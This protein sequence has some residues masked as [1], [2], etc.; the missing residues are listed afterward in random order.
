MSQNLGAHV[1]FLMWRRVARETLVCHWGKQIVA[2]R[3]D[4]EGGLAGK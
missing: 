4:Q 2:M 1:F 3:E